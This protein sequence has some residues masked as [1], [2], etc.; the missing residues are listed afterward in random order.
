MQNQQ[1]QQEDPNLDFEK[2]V[3]WK[4]KSNMFS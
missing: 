2:T 3:V 4:V 1:Q